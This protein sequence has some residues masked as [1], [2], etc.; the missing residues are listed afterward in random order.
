MTERYHRIRMKLLEYRENRSHNRLQIKLFC[1]LKTFRITICFLSEDWYR[2]TVE[3]EFVEDL[4][5]D[6]LSA[7][8]WYLEPYYEPADFDL[9][10]FKH[11]YLT[12]F[13]VKHQ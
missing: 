1:S 3:R 10:D 8:G 13:T 12:M 5:E 6:E 2:A 11:D 9:S 4:L 7:S